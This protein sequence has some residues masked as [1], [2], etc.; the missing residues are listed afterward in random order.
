VGI[1]D[2]M[3]AEAEEAH[4]HL[5]ELVA[6]VDEDLMMRYLEDDTFDADEIRA[7][8]RKATLESSLVPVLCGSSLKNKGVQQMLDAIVYFLPSP[9]DV[10]PVVGTDP[11]TDEELVRTVDADQPFAGLV[12]KIQADPHV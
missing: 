9:L 1:P 3:K 4:K 12:F 2:N 10:P 5:V 11:K 6:E 8:L 7:A